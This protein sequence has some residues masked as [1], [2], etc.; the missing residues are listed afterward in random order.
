MSNFDDYINLL[1]TIN[2]Q[3][4]QAR[5]QHPLRPSILLHFRRVSDAPSQHKIGDSPEHILLHPFF[6]L[7]VPYLRD[8]FA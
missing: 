5:I 2:M 3:I 7:R 6:C 8:L 1:G 4:K